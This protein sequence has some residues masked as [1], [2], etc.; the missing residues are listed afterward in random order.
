MLLVQR[1]PLENCC[2][3]IYSK[4]HGTHPF[5]SPLIFTISGETQYEYFYLSD[6]ITWFRNKLT[7][8]GSQLCYK[9][10]PRAKP[11]SC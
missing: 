1:P 2:V 6:E 8:P 9:A 7:C 5:I 11:S 4:R 3:K 10:D